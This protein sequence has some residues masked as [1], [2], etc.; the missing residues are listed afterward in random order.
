MRQTLRP[1]GP[2]RSRTG[3]PLSSKGSF[4]GGEVEHS[5]PARQRSMMVSPL[6]LR[7]HMAAS[8]LSRSG[9]PGAPDAQAACAETA[10]RI[11]R[12]EEAL[13]ALLRGD[14]NAVEGAKRVLADY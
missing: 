2:R 6:P 14:P 1:I 7:M 13:L 4:P 9:D 5:R 11:V 10:A 3:R 8:M 12:L